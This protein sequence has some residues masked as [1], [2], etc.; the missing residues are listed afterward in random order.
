MSA[1]QRHTVR[2]TNRYS[3]AAMWLMWRLCALPTWAISATVVIA[4]PYLSTVPGF[5]S[6]MA[7]AAS[8]RVAEVWNRPTTTYVG[9]IAGIVGLAIF[10]GLIGHA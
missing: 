10:S 8:D 2:V 5:L 1:P 9:V 7:R 4:G 6:T 3:E